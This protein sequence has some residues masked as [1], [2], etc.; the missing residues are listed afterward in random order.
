MTLKCLVTGASGLL[1]SAIAERMSQ[2]MTVVG[3]GH[4]NAYEGVRCDLRDPSAVHTLV[5]RVSPDVVIHAA[6]YKDP[7]FCEANQEEARRMNV[8]ATQNLCDALP[9]ETPLIFIS[10]D[11]VFD[12]ESQPNTE[13]SS[14]GA[15]NVYGETK[16]ASEDIVAQRPHGLSLRVPVLIAGGASLE[17]SGYVGQ[18]IACVRE[19]TPITLDH[20]HVRYPTWTHDVADVIA[21]L[22]RHG[23][24]GVIHYSGEE[25]STRYEG[26]LEAARV[27]GTSSAHI[28]PSEGSV[29]R[30]AP[31]PH[32]SA[33]STQKLRSLGYSRFTPFSQ[34]IRSV[35][36]S[37]PA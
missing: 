5:D 22:V 18:L 10:S 7:D 16:I 32:N 29:P 12:G 4:Q 9:P 15:I 35:A 3:C 25:A 36:D 8:G 1:G 13:A 31:R 27:L 2:E 34:V 28:L 21:F 14:R 23:T 19:K 24:T 6:A 20:Y 11:Y 26:A 37:F 33:L 17:T 30:G